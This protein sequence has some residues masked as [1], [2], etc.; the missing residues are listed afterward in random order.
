MLLSWC[1][2]A[3]RQGL[4]FIFSRKEEAGLEKGI[5]LLRATQ[6]TQ[7]NLSVCKWPYFAC[8]QMKESVT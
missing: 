2:N 3:K 8:L 4:I 6:P 7:G 5:G 1:N